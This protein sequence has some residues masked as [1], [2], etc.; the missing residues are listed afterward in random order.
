MLVILAH[1]ERQRVHAC[2]RAA[3]ITP[4]HRCVASGPHVARVQAADHAEQGRRPVGRRGDRPACRP[5]TAPPAPGRPGRRA[6]RDGTVDRGATVSSRAAVRSPAASHGSAADRGAAAPRGSMKPR[7]TPSA[8]PPGVCGEQPAGSDHLAGPPLGPGDAAEDDAVGVDEQA[9]RL[10]SA[11]ASPA[12]SAASWPRSS[13]TTMTARTTPAP[14]TAG[15]ERDAWGG[16]GRRSNTVPAQR[17]AAGLDRAGDV[18]PSRCRRAGWPRRAAQKTSAVGL[19]RREVEIAGNPFH[20]AGEEG[21]C[22][23]RAGRR[24]PPGRREGRA[25]SCWAVSIR[26]SCSRGDRVGPR[27]RRCARRRARAS[28]RAS[29]CTTTAQTAS[30]ARL[31]IPA[32]MTLR[33]TRKASPAQG[34]AEHRMGHE[35]S[36]YPMRGRTRKLWRCPRG[37][38]QARGVK[39]FRRWIRSPSSSTSRRSS[40]IVT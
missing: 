7:P 19:H 2:A 17:G 28:R 10:R 34:T 38:P 33:Q 15:A 18:A 29:P 32:T 6:R 12:R 24:A 11:A 9:S 14:S 39:V 20:H 4:V 1:A 16:P 13:A 36:E 37:P 22:R 21:R 30:A 35:T 5:T 3:L 27:P 25:S 8:F 40:S 23:P 31:I 26:R